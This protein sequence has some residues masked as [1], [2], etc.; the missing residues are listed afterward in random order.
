MSESSLPDDPDQWPTDPFEVLGVAR[1]VPARDLKRAYAQRIRQYKPEQKPEEFRRIRQA[2]EIVRQLMEWGALQAASGPGEEPAAPRD[3]SVDRYW[4][5]AI[6]GNAPVAYA[7]I[8]AE[9]RAD[10]RRPDLPLR[11]YWLRKLFPE[12][13][14]ERPAVEWLVAAVRQP[15]ANG[16]A[17]E[18]LQRE[19]HDQPRETLSATEALIDADWPTAEL[20]ELAAGRW[21][22]ALRLH[23]LET[24]RRDLDRLQPRLQAH[25]EAAWFR[26]Q[27]TALDAV[28]WW[29]DEPDASEI[30]AR[31]HDEVRRLEHRAMNE[32]YIFDRLDYLFVLASAWR[33]FR[34]KYP[35]PMS[36]GELIPVSW[37][38]PVPRLLPLTERVLEEIVSRPHEWLGWFDR[39]WEKAPPVLDFFSRIVQQY[40]DRLENQPVDPH[41]PT[42]LARS[43][44]DCME[45]TTSRTYAAM[46]SIIMQFCLDE[47]V[48]VEMFAA[49]APPVRI[50]APP[51][52]ELTLHDALARDW[53]LR[54]IC[55]SSRLFWA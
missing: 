12:V 32:P 42:H 25:E 50:D 24:I 30:Q 11:L 15:G 21:L 33:N 46:R 39:F 51:G 2:Y 18:L 44:A 55:W 17:R 27:I 20:G 47:F 34:S 9:A 26:L 52:M 37:S 31:C 40:S 48:T 16:Q 43:A 4:R 6:D 10:P 45:R 19:F 7:G 41:A 14:P 8:L 22:A 29:A 23:E 5:Q 1:D 53:P 54:L 38:A 35:V 49:V 28:A 3:D 13:D 36:L